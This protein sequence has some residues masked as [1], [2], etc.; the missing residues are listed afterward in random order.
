MSKYSTNGSY[1]ISI[2]ALLLLQT[3]MVLGHSAAS[4]AQT[5]P[6]APAEEQVLQ[7]I[8]VTAQK[9]SELELRRKNDDPE[10]QH[11][12]RRCETSPRRE[13]WSGSEPGADYDPR[14]RRV[15]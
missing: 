8:V 10:R 2:K 9:R 6:S 7:D 11:D 5:T 12:S 14:D 1:G 15:H 4:Q 13:L 3:A